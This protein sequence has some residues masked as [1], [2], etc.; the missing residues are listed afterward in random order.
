MDTVWTTVK[1]RRSV[2]AEAAETMPGMS[3]AAIVQRALESV[4]AV[5]SKRSAP[6][7]ASEGDRSEGKA[8]ARTV[9]QPSPS[10]ARLDGQTDIDEM[11][12]SCPNCAETLVPAEGRP[13]VLVCPDCGHVREPS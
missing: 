11:L 4:L 10:P 5:P 7:R 12:A 3:N 13:D 8:S 9:S 6:T 2:L 1:V